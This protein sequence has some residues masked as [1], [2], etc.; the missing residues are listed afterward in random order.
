MEDFFA[1][2][3]LVVIVNGSESFLA[4]GLMT[5]MNAAGINTVLAG[6]K[7]KDI[8]DYRYKANLFILFMDDAINEY[9][10]TIAYLKEV[11][12]DS[13]RKLLLIGE[14][15]QYDYVTKIIDPVLITEW[16]KR[17]LEME[18]FLK[19]IKGYL[20]EDNEKDENQKSILIVDDDITYMRTVYEWLKDDYHVDMASNGM[21]A[22]SH[23]SRK[24]VDLVLLDYE[25]PVVNGP[26]IFEMLKSDSETGKI[27]V[28][29]LTGHGE[30]ESIMSVINLKPVDYILKTIDKKS[31]LSKLK[32][33]F[34]KA[35]KKNS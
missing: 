27:P 29:F 14:Q 18:S 1:K 17:P 9:I 5:K 32:S 30:R 21:Q 24:K 10:N 25:M 31:L 28:M 6:K 7:V 20:T 12:S 34:S 22:I 26:Q 3:G 35:G 33:F 4:N 2:Q 16:Y 15:T 11:A 19:S 23:L 13:D 8:E